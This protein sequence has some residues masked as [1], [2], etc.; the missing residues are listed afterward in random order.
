MRCNCS[1]VVRKFNIG[2]F[3]VQSLGLAFIN[4][5]KINH[6][7]SINSQ[8]AHF[9]LFGCNNV[10]LNNLRL[11]APFDSPNTDGI[12]IGKSQN[13]KISQTTIGT[14]DDCISLLP[15]SNNINISDVFCGPGHGISVGSMGGTGDYT[16]D[17]V[18]GLTVKNCTFS[19]TSNGIRIKTRASSISGVASDFTFKDIAMNNVDNPIIIDQKYCPHPPCDTTV[20][21]FIFLVLYI[22]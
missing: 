5:G 3:F 2:D 6:I 10:S 20:H 4:N 19:N 18:L 13:V 11:S 8:N 15:G 14:G 7:S 9:S 16:N 12:K 22:H 17:T 21:I 1:L